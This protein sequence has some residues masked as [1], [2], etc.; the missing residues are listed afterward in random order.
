MTQDLLYIVLSLSI[1]W[2]TIFLCWLIYQAGRT[3]RNLNELVEYIGHKVDMAEDM[4]HFVEKRLETISGAMTTVTGL[5]GT[6][7]EKFVVGA[8]TRKLEERATGRKKKK[9]QPDE[10]KIS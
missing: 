1:L 3:L 5:F 8:L 2:F 4:F 10:E 6:L 9:A 7:V